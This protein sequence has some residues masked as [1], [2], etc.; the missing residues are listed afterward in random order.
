MEE[1]RGDSGSWRELIVSE[2]CSRERCICGHTET[3][4]Q[5]LGY[6]HGNGG[7]PRKRRSV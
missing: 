6:Y 7:D 5:L 3:D 2:H 4:V 1:L